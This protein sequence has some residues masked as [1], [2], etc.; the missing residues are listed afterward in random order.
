MP[1]ATHGSAL[2]VVP[3]LA[4][5]AILS[6]GPATLQ[7][8]PAH[9]QEPA[10][11]PRIEDVQELA[12]AVYAALR[13]GNA[14]TGSS[15][16]W[17]SDSFKG[18]NGNTDVAFTVAVE[19]ARLNGAAVALYLLATPRDAPSVPFDRLPGRPGTSAPEVLQG[20]PPPSVAFEAVYSVDLSSMGVDPVAGVYRFSRAFAV[21][22]GEYDVYAALAPIPAPG[23]PARAGAASPRNRIMV[24]KETV[25]APD[26]W[27]TG[28]AASSVVMLDR[29]EPVEPSLDDRRR[30]SDPYV[31]G[32]ARVV[33]AADAD[34]RRDER[35][36]VA[37]FVYNAG[38][39]PGGSPD[40]T[41]D[42]L[43]YQRGP[44]GARYHGR[45]RPQ[46]FNADTLAG[47]DPRAGHQIVASQAVP[48]QAFPAGAYRLDIRIT[49]NAT[50]ESVV[51]SVDFSVLGR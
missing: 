32:G 45:T 50:G 30:I 27:S 37:F 1:A 12:R 24:V 40:V 22:P 18:A 16:T 7:S 35:L 39:G 9:G 14:A 13:H 41:V 48:L 20:P 44:E 47:F 6:A 25:T 26:Y 49:D 29:V 43:L 3:P 46:R 42:Y 4:V 8:R 2:A 23:V 17:S 11:P 10:G 36:S 21:S 51:R 5:A 19:R 28:L 34:F 33:P 31:M 38:P 15:F